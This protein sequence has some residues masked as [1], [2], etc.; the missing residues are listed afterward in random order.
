MNNTICNYLQSLGWFMG[1][2]AALL[3]IPHAKTAVSLL[4][5]HLARQDEP[6]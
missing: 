3:A 1:G 2:L 4:R 5:V 6:K